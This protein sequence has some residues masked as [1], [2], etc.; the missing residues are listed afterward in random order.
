[1]D[2]CDGARAGLVFAGPVLVHQETLRAHLLTIH[3][4]Y[5]ETTLTLRQL[6]AIHDELHG[7]GEWGNAPAPH[8]HRPAPPPERVVTKDWTW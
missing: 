5:V 8:T 4:L 3:G 1:M 2:A 7:E 6:T